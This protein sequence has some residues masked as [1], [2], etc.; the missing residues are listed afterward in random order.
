MFTYSLQLNK[1]FF[2][3]H[4]NLHT[5]RCIIHLLS[6]HDQEA[7]KLRMEQARKKAR[8]ERAEREEKERQIEEVKK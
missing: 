6:V 1:L 2:L 5:A 7:A 8:E 4:C 3:S